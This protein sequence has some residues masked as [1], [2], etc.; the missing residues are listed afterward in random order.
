MT[1][2]ANDPGIPPLFRVWSQAGTWGM[3]ASSNTERA[4]QVRNILMPRQLSNTADGDHD[5]RTSNSHGIVTSKRDL[6]KDHRID[7]I[8]QGQAPTR[9]V[10]G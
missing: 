8:E 6:Q 9:K 3:S 7:E 10:V 1:T 5:G 4:T 2:T